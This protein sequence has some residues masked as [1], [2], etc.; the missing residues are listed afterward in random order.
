MEYSQN[1]STRISKQGESPS[2]EKE[3]SLKHAGVGR[4]RKNTKITQ[5]LSSFSSAINK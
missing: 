3:T 4:G 5:R 1:T 2:I